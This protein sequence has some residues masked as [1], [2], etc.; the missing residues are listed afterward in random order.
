MEVDQEVEVDPEV[1][2]RV[3]HLVKEY[4]IIEIMRDILAVIIDILE[5]EEIILIIEIEEIIII[6]DLIIIIEERKGQ[7]KEKRC[8]DYFEN[9]ICQ[10]GDNCPYEHGDNK[11]TLNSEVI[12]RLMPYNGI[13][14]NQSNIQV[15]NQNNVPLENNES[16]D[17]YDPETM[18][19]YRR[20]RRKK[21]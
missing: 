1:D 19:N 10:R 6:T 12:T 9:G 15:N 2:L 11:I 4:L 20:K 18:T 7:W 13:M 21:K 8:F 5:I 16:N 17:T 3:N 14:P